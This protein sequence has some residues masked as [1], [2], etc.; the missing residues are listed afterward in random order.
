[1][2]IVCNTFLVSEKRKMM[3]RDGVFDFRIY[4]GRYGLL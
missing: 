4:N 2:R 3:K 1:M